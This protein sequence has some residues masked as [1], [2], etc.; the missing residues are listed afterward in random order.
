[1]A[2]PL[3]LPRAGSLPGSGLVLSSGRLLV[4]AQDYGT[5]PLRSSAARRNARR[6]G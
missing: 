6:W 2:G 4:T 5:E 3:V 1:V